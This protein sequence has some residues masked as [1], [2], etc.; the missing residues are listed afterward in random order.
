MPRIRIIEIEHFRGIKHM[1]WFP[2]AG[3]NCLIGPGD[4]CK[5]TVLEAIALCIGQRRA[6]PLTDSDFFNLEVS[7]PIRITIT[8]GEL[9]ESLLDIEAYGL[10]LHGFIIGANELVEEPVDGSEPVLTIRVKVEQDLQPEWELVSERANIAGASRDF[11]WKDRAIVQVS[12][13]SGIGSQ[14]FTWGRGSILNRVSE[15]RPDAAGVIA[16]LLRDVRSTFGDSAQRHLEETVRVVNETARELGING[17]ADTSVLLDTSSIS[18]SGGGVSLHDSAGVPLSGLGSGSSRLLIAGLQRHAARNSTVVLADEIEYGLEPHRIIRLLTSLGSKEPI[19][20]LQVFL[21]THSPIVI[22]ELSVSQ[23]WVLRRLAD[24][25]DCMAVSEVDGIQGV[26]RAHPEAFL[27]ASVLACEGASEVGFIRG[28]DQYRTTSGHVSI[29]ALG[30]VLVDC[31]GG[32]NVTQRANA[33]RRMSYRTAVLRDDDVLPDAGLEQSFLAAGGE[34]FK[35]THGRALEDE[36]F[37]GLPE[38]EVNTLLNLAVGKMGEPLIDSHIRSAS[39]N[40]ITLNHCREQLTGP[41]RCVLGIAARSRNNKWF[42]TFSDMEVIGR[43]IV[44]PAM[45]SMDPAFRSVIDGVFQWIETG[46]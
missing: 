41:V 5:S 10:Y 25:L 18:T 44:G 3:L 32:D 14:H 35:W 15:E 2:R 17:G 21:A 16:Q 34:V 36:L 28:I 29:A 1:R 27:A 20:P 30:C 9:P 11:A 7:Q 45:T 13:L 22:C 39:N 19:P 6:S 31:R 24:R 33:I 42:K 4:S 46:V 23:L 38:A 8:L 40:T 12:K 43:D 26:V 37:N